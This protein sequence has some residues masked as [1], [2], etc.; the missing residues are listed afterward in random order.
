MVVA[1]HGVA[2]ELPLRARLVVLV[3]TQ[4]FD[5]REHRYVDLPIADVLHV[6]G[7]AGRQGV[8][9]AGRFALLCAASKK[10]HLRKFLYEPLPVESHL[11]HTLAD[12]LCA[13]V[14]ARTVDSK[15]AAVDYLTWTLYYRRLTQNPNYYGLEELG[16]AQLS[17]HLSA[18]VE[19]T[20]AELEEAKALA[21][22]D[23]ADEVAPLNLGMIAAHYYI[24]HTTIELFA[25]SLKRTSK[26]HALLQVLAEAAE[27]DELPVRR[28]DERDMRRLAAHSPLKLDAA[29]FHDPHTK[30]NLLAQ[31]HFS[32]RGL[33]GDLARDQVRLC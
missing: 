2:F 9:G 13:E 28:G 14:V 19:S 10:A 15:Q 1:T 12:H 17:D 4:R 27:F 31:A 30:A 6:M 16:R 3:G 26:L 32:R 25:L 5:G 21:V 33:L 22:D 8:D 11:D 29:R 18:L 24:R 23:A 20:L 7:K